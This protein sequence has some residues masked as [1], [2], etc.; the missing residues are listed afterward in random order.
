MKVCKVRACVACL[1]PCL[2]DSWPLIMRGS[3][4]ALVLVAEAFKG[5]KGVSFTCSVLVC[6]DSGVFVR[7]CLP[8]HVDLHKHEALVISAHTRPSEPKNNIAVL[9]KHAD[10]EVHG[11]YQ[12]TPA[13]LNLLHDQLF[14][15]KHCAITLC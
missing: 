8:I 14:V 5:F 9:V 11:K 4:D 2:I 10:G 3:V 13:L 12:M 1:R 6:P 15:T 7:Q